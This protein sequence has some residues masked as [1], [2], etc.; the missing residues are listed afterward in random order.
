MAGPGGGSRGGGGGRGS[1]FGGGGRGGMGGGRGGGFG[2]RPGGY[3]YRGPMFGGP[4]FGGFGYRRRY[5]YYGGGYY[6]GGGCLGGLLGLLLLPF[7]LI[8]MA[9]V[10]VFSSL[11]SSFTILSDGGIVPYNEETFQDYANEQYLAEYGSS[12][13]GILLVFLT[14]ENNYD[15]RYIGW[16]GNHVSTDVNYLFGGEGSELGMEIHSAIPENYKYSLS[17]NLTAVTNR[18]ATRASAV[19]SG[20]ICQE[21]QDGMKSH[22]VNRS[23]L[24]LDTETV[25]MALTAF[26]ERTGIP[27]TIVVD[28]MEDVFGKE[29]PFSVIF[30]LILAGG[31]VIV[32]IVL[33]VKAVRKRKQGPQN[34]GGAGNPGDPNGPSNGW[35][36][37]QYG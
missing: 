8:A 16:V 28:E 32:A 35:G 1:G 34:P 20:Y 27:M 18:M 21:S 31:V 13:D 7:M 10:L 9:A 26:T 36:N 17:S 24:S 29:I 23:A 22:V 11:A 30:T 15:F 3:G 14:A 25:N 37:P 2:G 5:G 19:N 33:I 4:M 6:G 12:E